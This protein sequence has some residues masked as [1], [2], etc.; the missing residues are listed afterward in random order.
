MS[1]YLWRIPEEYPEKL[2]GRYE[3]E[4]SPDRF[5]FRQGKPIKDDLLLSTPIIKFEVTESQLKKYDCLVNSSMIPL[6]SPKLA[7]LLSKL[8][9]KDIELIDANV[10]CVDGEFED[11]KILNVTHLIKGIDHELSKY[12]KMKQADAILGFKRLV[13]KPGCLKDYHLARDEEYKGH[14]LVSQSI[15]EAFKSEKI[16]G[17]WLAMPEEFYNY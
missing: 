13:H 7:A 2:I 17:V 12:T 6:V 8:A 15:F 9:G 3:R 5:L 4:R 11:Y 10:E 16:T 14:L 1:I